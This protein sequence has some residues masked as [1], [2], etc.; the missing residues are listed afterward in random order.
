[1][2]CWILAPTL[3]LASASPGATPSRPR[4]EL[5]DAIETLRSTGLN[6][7][8]SEPA[9]QAWKQLAK[10]DVSDLPH[11]LAAMD[12]ANDV[13]RNWLRSAI[14][15]VLDRARAEKKKLPLSELEAFLADRRH[16]PQSRRFAY[17]LI[18]E[19]DAHAPD[20]ILPG[21]LDDPSQD[22]RRDAVAR[23]LDEANK[24]LAA[25]KK[26]QALA[27]YQQCLA[28]AR[29]KD[30]ID[31]TATK[32]KELGQPVDIARHYGFI[33]DWKL[34]GPFPN[35]SQNGIETAYPPEK[36]IDLNAAYNGKAGKIRWK[37][38]VTSAENGKVDLKQVIGKQPDAIAYA[39]T[40]FT[41][42]REQPAEVRIASIT[43]LKAWLNGELALARY[44]AFTGIRMDSYI[45]KV[46]LKK[47]KNVLL[48]KLC[49]DAPPELR[50]DTWWF[51]ARVCDDMGAAILSSTRPSSPPSAKNP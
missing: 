35:P 45:A 7:L 13:A 1:M 42:D 28:A 5:M 11:L 14:D 26:D 47:G 21:M 25:G 2:L 51:Q 22:M 36:Q 43:A 39:M 32:L 41:S 34:V 15:P 23:L 30:Q 50:L 48:L 38:H 33:Q 49:K 16:D 18:V 4:P 3:L 8:N 40:E 6:G 44:D 20:R 37:D 24:T 19:A 9:T 10:L 29:E 46:R 27:L 31:K 12:G 17:E